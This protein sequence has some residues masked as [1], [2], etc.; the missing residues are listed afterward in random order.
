MSVTVEHLPRDHGANR[1]CSRSASQMREQVTEKDTSTSSS[2]LR[3]SAISWSRSEQPRPKVSTPHSMSMFAAR[4][5]LCKKHWRF[6]CD[7]ASIILNGAARSG[8]RGFSTITACAASKAALRSFPR[9]WTSALQDRK[10]RV[11][12]LTQAGSPRQ[13]RTSCRRARRRFMLKMVP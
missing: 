13:H 1:R 4:W 11:N 5:S 6:L 12:V 9:T 10:I 8:G 3:V 2:R 7:H